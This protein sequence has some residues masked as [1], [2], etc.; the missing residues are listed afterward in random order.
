MRTYT[1]ALEQ[2]L[3]LRVDVE[4]AVVAVLGEVKG[5]DL[6]HVLILAF[7]FLFL[8]LEGDTADGASLNTLH[9]GEC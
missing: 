7:T 2:V 1:E 9:P 8:Q 5:G 6:G 3:G 4:G